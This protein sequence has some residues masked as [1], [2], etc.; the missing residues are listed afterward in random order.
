[1]SLD[2]A[3]HT[4]DPNALFQMLVKEAHDAEA[5]QAAASGV[6]AN[7]ASDDKPADGGQTKIA[8]DTGVVFDL[9]FFDKLASNDVEAGT[10]LNAFVS[11]ALEQGHD[12]EAIGNFV[13]QMES[14]AR[15]AP[16][17]ATADTPVADKP[18]DEPANDDVAVDA[19]DAAKEEAE[20]EGIEQA[21]DDELAHNP[22]AKAAG[23]T[24]EVIESWMLGEAKGE[25][26]FHGRQAV[27]DIVEKIASQVIPSDDMISESLKAL[28]DAGLDVTAVE[29]EIETIKKEASTVSV[30]EGDAAKKA[31]ELAA[32][33]QAV[34][35]SLTV[36]KC[37]GFDVDALVKQAEEKKKMSG[38]KKALIAGG[39]LA[40]LGGGAF[41]AK[42][43]S[44]TVATKAVGAMN[45]IKSKMGK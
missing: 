24:R 18:A 15:G 22:L 45:A 38:G 10:H 31:R 7:E 44:G 19:F 26:Y 8:N 43:H 16:P 27:G 41:L 13:A 20:A 14:D 2:A 9:A 39:S 34:V 21:I 37:A 17:A 12:P 35:E 40:A 11:Q 23:V 25:S 6:P 3:T 32:A 30:T 5:T 33:E 4:T 42:R 1:M 36:L 28:K 29:T